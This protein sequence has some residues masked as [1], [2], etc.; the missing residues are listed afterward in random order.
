VGHGL[1]IVDVLIPPRV[2]DSDFSKVLSRILATI[3]A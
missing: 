2:D 3:A 1:Y